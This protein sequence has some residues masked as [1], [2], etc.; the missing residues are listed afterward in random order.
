[1]AFKVSTAPGFAHDRDPETF[2]GIEYP[3][4]K[5]DNLNGYFASTATTLQAAKTNVKMLLETSQGERLMQPQLGTGLRRYLFEQATDELR[6]LIENDIVDS[7]AKWL[8]FL[9]VVDIT[10]NMTNNT[11]EISVS[12]ALSGN[13]GSTASVAVSIG[14]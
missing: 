13:P 6:I 8:P 7:F 5:G 9:T 1:M 2:I 4:K 11:L 10:V 14:E 3:L 12:F